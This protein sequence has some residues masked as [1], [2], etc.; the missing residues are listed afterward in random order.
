M[1]LY[2]LMYIDDI[3]IFCPLSVFI[4]GEFPSP[5][6]FSLF[7]CLGLCRHLSTSLHHTSAILTDI[8]INVNNYQPSRQRYKE[9]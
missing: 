5:R 6:S 8:D 7:R 9:Y 4:K 2:L 3:D 1:K